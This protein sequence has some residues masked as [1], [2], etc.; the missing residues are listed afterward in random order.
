MGI[1]MKSEIIYHYPPDL[2]TLLI[3]AVHY[4]NKGKRDV[5]LFFRG[6]GVS[7]KILTGSAY[8]KWQMDKNSISK[9]EI[10]REILSAV[11]VGE[12]AYLS[13]RRE[14]IKRIIEFD[15]FSM[16]WENDRLPAQGIVA[17]IQK[18]VSA[19]DTVTRIINDDKKIRDERRKIQN[20]REA[21]KLRYIESLNV[22]KKEFSSIFREVIPQKRGKMLERVLNKLFKIYNISIREALTIKGNNAE[23]II[24]QI[25][26]VIDFE[27]HL[28]FIEMKWWSEPLGVQQISEHL[29]RVYHRSEA[30]AII[31][32]ASNFTAPAITTCK[33]A[34]QQKVVILCTLEEIF[35]LLE[36]N[37]D[38]ISFLRQKIH[39]A[40]I[41]KNPF[42]EIR[43]S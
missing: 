30:R 33:D 37:R 42:A 13:Q 36:N 17:Q 21:E 26:G 9:R 25:D 14:I 40:Q 11:N 35:L 41:E 5:F 20:E 34:L 6:A 15:A 28:Y 10:A 39:A 22:L 1:N 27:G 12:D 23:R 19:K 2:M 3:E 4:L 29:V 31:I 16:C 43:W 7:E 24:E 32:S 18:L 38:L 8:L